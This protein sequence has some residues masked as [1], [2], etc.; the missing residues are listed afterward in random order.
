MKAPRLTGKQIL[1]AC[2]IVTVPVHV[3]RLCRSGRS[4]RS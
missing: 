3:P 1:A 2:G 4:M